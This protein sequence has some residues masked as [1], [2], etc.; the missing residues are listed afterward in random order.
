MMRK[1]KVKI[2][3]NAFIDIYNGICCIYHSKKYNNLTNESS[4]YEFREKR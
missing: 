2:K 4:E 1:L 3:S